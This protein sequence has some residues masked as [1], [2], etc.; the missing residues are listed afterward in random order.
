MKMNIDESKEYNDAVPS[1]I[2]DEEKALKTASSCIDLD[3][4]L[5]EIS[6]YSEYTP[7]PS[8]TNVEIECE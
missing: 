2:T 1:E 8:E 5:S 4:A 3:T 7:A 6:I